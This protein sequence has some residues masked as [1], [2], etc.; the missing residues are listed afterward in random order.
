V[1]L[2]LCVPSV[3][4][5]DDRGVPDWVVYPEEEWIRITPRQAG[6]DVEKFNKVLAQAKVYGTQAKIHDGTTWGTT[7]GGVKVGPDDWSAVL[8]RGGYMVHT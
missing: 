8:T 4:A 2:L 5:Q 6:L 3:I 7:W 1:V